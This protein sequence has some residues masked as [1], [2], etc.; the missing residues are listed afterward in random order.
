MPLA[1][2]DGLTSASPNS[3]AYGITAIPPA[4]SPRHSGEQR[5]V[6]CSERSID[7]IWTR[8]SLPRKRG[9]LDWRQRS[10]ARVERL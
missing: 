3:G 5:A 8:E 2:T 4:R 6:L 1:I 7:L 9:G 10:V